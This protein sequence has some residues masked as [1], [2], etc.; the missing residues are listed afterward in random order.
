MSDLLTP[1]DRDRLTGVHPDLVRVVERARG[2]GEPFFV[3]EG[4]RTME[5]QRELFA[6]GASR[7]LRSRHLTGHAVDLGPIPLDW[8]DRAAFARLAAAMRSAAE[9]E[10]VALRWGGDFRGFYDGPHFELPWDRYPG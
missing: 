5:R 8:N 9:A 7:T 10:E 2:G 4:L 1:R 3:I 6:K